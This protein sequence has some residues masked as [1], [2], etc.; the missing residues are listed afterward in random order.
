MLLCVYMRAT[1]YARRAEMCNVP[2]RV[3]TM[4]VTCHIPSGSRHTNNQSLT[5]ASQ[6]LST[7][8]QR[9]R[10]GERSQLG[11]P[12]FGMSKRHLILPRSGPT[13]TPARRGAKRDSR[14]HYVPYVYALSAMRAPR[15]TQKC[16]FGDN[17]VQEAPGQ[18]G[19][20][21]HC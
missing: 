15:A 7:V 18:V 9:A 12:I 3:H 8:P 16:T 20:A 17:N 11:D 6:V 2:P 5:K 10:A 19:W 14:T 1:P 13:A 4:Y 21:I